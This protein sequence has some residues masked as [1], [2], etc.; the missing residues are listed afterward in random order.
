MAEELTRILTD[1]LGD[2]AAKER[3]WLAGFSIVG[4]CLFYYV[5][6]PIAELLMGPEHYAALD[7]DKLAEHIADFSLAALGL[8]PFPGTRAAKHAGA[9]KS[10]R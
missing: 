6:R 2:E 3:G 7:I 5:H 9:G 8:K 10:R 4:Q 1:I